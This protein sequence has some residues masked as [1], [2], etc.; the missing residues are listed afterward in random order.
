MPES[1]SFRVLGVSVPES[2]GP[3]SQVLRVPG[4][5][6]SR[7]HVSGSRVSSLRVPYPGSQGLVLD[8]AKVKSY[9]YCVSQFVY[10]KRNKN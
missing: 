5:R 1:P 6:V 10:E 7:S 4:L 3:G 8:Y 2:Q 9:I